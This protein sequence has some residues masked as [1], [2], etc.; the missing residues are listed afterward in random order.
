MGLIDY[1]ALT[2][3]LVSAYIF[4]SLTRSDQPFRLNTFFF[5]A[6]LTNGKKF[7]ASVAAASTSL[8]TVVVFFI[9]GVEQY[10]IFLVWCGI[11]YFTGQFGL[12][13]L[14][15]KGNIESS[16]L[17]TLSDFW[18]SYSKGKISAKV[19]SFLTIFAFSFMLF[20]ELFIGSQILNYYLEGESIWLRL[21]S[22]ILLLL[23]VS[24]YVFRGGMYAVFKS[25]LWQYILMLISIIALAFVS[26]T[27]AI[28]VS[29]TP[30][31]WSSV[32]EI[33]DNLEL[34]AFL[35]WVT[36][37]NL[38]LPFT[39]LSS[40][41]RLASTDSVETA[42]KGLR[43]ISTGFLILWILPVISMLL[44]KAYGIQFS[45]ISQ[46][47]DFLR[48]SNELLI[49]VSFA[50]IFVGFTSA[51]FS[52]ADSALIACALSLS[53]KSTFKDIFSNR[54]YKESK[55]IILLFIGLIIILESFLFYAF[56]NQATSS[57]LSIVYVVF[58]QLSL[59]A[60]LTGY[61]IYNVVKRNRIYVL[62]KLQDTVIAIG[63][64]SGWLTLFI[65]NFYGNRYHLNSNLSIML[66]S[67]VGMAI[68]GSLLAF[69]ILVLRP[70]NTEMT[71][72]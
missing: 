8:A 29:D 69:S 31:S 32:Y 21:L 49:Y 70:R 60:P 9:T 14:L 43:D 10:G 18:L 56:S 39:Q 67:F 28:S 11:T 30:P 20:I 23:I 59:I 63:L 12:L 55:F 35:I 7:G 13:Y 41:Q 4:M 16:N 61:I 17:T 54:T 46:F 72:D 50:V 51:L 33:N 3:V 6:H 64:V 5:N 24:V 58:S 53:D 34:T 45:N 65:F 62:S 66:G 1:V 57:F 47:F 36:I 68:S 22:F 19:I 71:Y 27:Y 40:W 25:D 52:T 15:K 48:N 26:F 2:F 37:Q 38:T 44:F 42:L